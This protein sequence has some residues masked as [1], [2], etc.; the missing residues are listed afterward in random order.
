M[1]LF[2]IFAP[3]LLVPL[4]IALLFRLA[5][6]KPGAWVYAAT[7]LLLMGYF[8]VLAKAGSEETEPSTRA[9]LLLYLDM[10][11]LI[12]LFIITPISLLLQ[13][14]FFKILEKIIR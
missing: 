14:G 9:W 5:H 10:A 4:I 3:Y 13:K 2:I 8:V 12:M 1:S 6:K 7:Y 11:Y